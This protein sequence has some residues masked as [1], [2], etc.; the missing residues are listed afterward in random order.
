MRSS[1]RALGLLVALAGC[2]REVALPNGDLP[3]DGESISFFLPVGLPGGEIYNFR[4]GYILS[5]PR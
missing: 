4:G 3:V 2:N 1:R 5:V